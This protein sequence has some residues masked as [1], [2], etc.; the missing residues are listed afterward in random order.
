[1]DGFF[2][3][4]VVE[5]YVVTPC[6]LGYPGDEGSRFLRNAGNHLHN[7]TLSNPEDQKLNS[8]DVSF[9]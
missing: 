2:V 7:C 1:V 6:V 3:F 8:T 4:T 5:V 9:M